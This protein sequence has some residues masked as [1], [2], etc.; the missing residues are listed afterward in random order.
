MKGS[1]WR[2]IIYCPYCLGN[3]NLMDKKL[4]ETAIIGW[5]LSADICQLIEEGSSKQRDL[6]KQISTMIF[7]LFLYHH[8]LTNIH[9]WSTNN[10][11]LSTNDHHLSTSDHHLLTHNHHLSTNN[12]YLSTSNHYLLTVIGVQIFQLIVH[13]VYCY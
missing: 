4:K 9:H 7:I 11:H 5:Y 6:G 3:Q 8:F 2:C 10:Q 1:V 13:L 12:H